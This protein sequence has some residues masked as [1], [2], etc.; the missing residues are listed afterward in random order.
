MRSLLKIIINDKIDSKPQTA[1]ASALLLVLFSENQ[2]FIGGEYIVSK[3]RTTEAAAH[4]YIGMACVFFWKYNL[5]ATKPS[6]LY[7]TQ[8][9]L[10]KA[11]TDSTIPQIRNL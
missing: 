11:I 8:Q 4:Q 10:Q 5:N 3:V 6:L 1:I 7:R 9:R 2:D